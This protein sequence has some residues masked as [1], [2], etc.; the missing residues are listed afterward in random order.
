MGG[1]YA[2]YLSGSGVP[3]AEHII[4]GKELIQGQG[5]IAPSGGLRVVQGVGGAILVHQFPKG[6][7]AVAVGQL[8]AGGE[9][10]APGGHPIVM[11]ALVIT[12]RHRFVGQQAGEVPLRQQ[13]AVGFFSFVAGRHRFIGQEAG[14]VPLRPKAALFCRDYGGRLVGGLGQAEGQGGIEL[15]PGL[16][17][18]GK[19]LPLIPQDYSVELMPQAAG[20]G[21]LG[22]GVFGGGGAAAGASRYGIVN[23]AEGLFLGVGYQFKGDGAAFPVGHQAQSVALTIQP[24][25][26]R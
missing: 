10:I 8:L 26:R 20:L 19:T 11:G 5:Y 22:D 4:A 17:V 1:E 14:E 25:V 13:V 24:P 7:E 15:F 18:F 2:G 23:A 9:H 21:G 3:D 6:L 12:G 16:A